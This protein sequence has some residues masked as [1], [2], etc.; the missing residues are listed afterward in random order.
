MSNKLSGGAERR[1]V[2][3]GEAGLSSRQVDRGSQ[4]PL[5]LSTSVQQA[6][7]DA[8]AKQTVLKGSRLLWN[9]ITSACKFEITTETPK[10]VI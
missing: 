10:T 4:P 9:Q 2:W 3:S 5:L 1:F 8:K 6:E 7:H